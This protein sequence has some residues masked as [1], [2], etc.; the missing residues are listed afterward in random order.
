M[1]LMQ[2]RDIDLQAQFAFPKT[3]RIVNIELIETVRGLPCMGCGEKPSDAHHITTRAAGGDDVPENLIPL[4]RAHHSM[5]HQMGA[6][7]MVSK[8]PCVKHWLKGAGREDILLK[9][10]A[11]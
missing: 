4:C 9:S 11:K 3:P 6:A 10:R 8:F 2:D 1:R 7:Y 5:W